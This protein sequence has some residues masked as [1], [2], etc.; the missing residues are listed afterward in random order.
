M[1]QRL[2]AEFVCREAVTVIV[3]NDASLIGVD[4]KF[5]QLRCPCVCALRHG[6]LLHCAQLEIS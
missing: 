4:G 3:R 2:F 5:E 6:V 1:F